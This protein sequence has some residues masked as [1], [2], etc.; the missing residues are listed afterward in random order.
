ML[1]A[2]RFKL[3]LNFTIEKELDDF[4]RKALDDLKDKSS[5]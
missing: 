3:Q 4:R 1:R 5:K 2:I